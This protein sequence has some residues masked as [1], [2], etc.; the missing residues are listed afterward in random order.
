MLRLEFD[1]K[2]YLGRQPVSN[3]IQSDLNNPTTLAQYCSEVEAAVILAALSESGIQGTTT[4]SFTTGFQAEAPGDVAIVV[5]QSDLPRAIEVLAELETMK[6]DIDWGS[7]D[8][9]EPE[10]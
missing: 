2:K 7:V 9:G 1:S 10:A 5:R 8:V 4:G 6:K 3:P